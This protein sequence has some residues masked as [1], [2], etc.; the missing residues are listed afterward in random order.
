MPCVL[1]AHLGSQKFEAIE[2]SNGAWAYEGDPD[3][4]QGFP[5][6]RLKS[7]GNRQTVTSQLLPSSFPGRRALGSRERKHG[8]LER[9]DGYRN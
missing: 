4:Y 3:P 1:P 2:P 9:K 5:R 8:G 7:N 6:C